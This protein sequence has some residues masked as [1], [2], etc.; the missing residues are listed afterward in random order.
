MSLTR[1]EKA[2]VGLSVLSLFIA[3][4]GAVVAAVQTTVASDS[5]ETSQRV[6]LQDRQISACEDIL[7]D[8]EIF[9]EQFERERTYVG[10]RQLI[11]DLHSQKGEPG[12]AS[13]AAHG[14][15]IDIEVVDVPN[16]L[17]A[18]QSDSYTIDRLQEVYEGD[19]GESARNFVRA[20]AV[21]S[22]YASDE[23]RGE[24]ELTQRTFFN[25]FSSAALQLALPPNSESS[26][27]PGQ[28]TSDELLGLM[29]A[30]VNEILE[31]CRGVMLGQKLEL[32]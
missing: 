3:T 19:L 25:L 14:Q 9:R 10:K 6:N 27:A 15:G 22:I 23:Q 13:I 16:F 24:F 20:L 21:L 26:P 32:F 5:V 4:C 29:N 17:K 8:F 28:K 18:V 31:A 11:V 30:E 1:F 2:S 12:S 7:V